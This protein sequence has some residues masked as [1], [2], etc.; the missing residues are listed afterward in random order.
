LSTAGPDETLLVFSGF[1][2]Y[3]GTLDPVFTF[4]MAF[5]GS[6]SGI[7]VSYFLGRIYGSS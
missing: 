3:K 7:T 5:L 2:I 6:V 4:S 1:L